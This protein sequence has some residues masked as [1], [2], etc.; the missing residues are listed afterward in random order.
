MI[1]NEHLRKADESYE[2][3]HDNNGDAIHVYIKDGYAKVFP[4]L[5]TLVS[6][7]YL[8]ERDVEHFEVIE[9]DLEILYNRG[10]YNY[11]KLKPIYRAYI[12]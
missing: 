1:H 3:R 8:D 4:S 7:V 12:P 2:I 10:D 6:Y 11:Y 9:Q 5:D